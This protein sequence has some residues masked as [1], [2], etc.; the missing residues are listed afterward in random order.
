MSL[1]MSI[2]AGLVGAVAV[3]CTGEDV[4]GSGALQLS[5]TGGAVMR[6]GYPYEEPGL[7]RL[8]FVDGWRL[9]FDRYIL[10]VGEVRLH[11]Q[12]PDQQSREGP[13]VASWT[14][15][16]VLDLMRPPSGVEFATLEDLPALRHDLGLDVVVATAAAENV[17]ATPEDYQ[18]MVDNGWTFWASGTA[19]RMDAG[20]S[21]SVRFSVGFAAPTRFF[22]CVN[23]VDATRGIAI[24][25]SSTVGAYI[26]PHSTHLFWDVLA[27]G[28]AQLRFDPW[29]AVAGDDGV[30]TAE[31]LASQDLLDLRDRDGS[32]L[33]DPVTFQ[34]V[35][36]DTASVFL[37]ETDL[38]SYTIYGFRQSVHFNGL[39]FCP[40]EP[41]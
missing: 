17:S 9:T 36:Y 23:G 33:L 1:R 24:E 40:W 35:R 26:Y 16:V 27:A 3:A 34:Q 8:A 10:A 15:P 20:T 41:L 25:A 6:E 7:S 12:L 18:T 29:A 28:D 19:T 37:R 32:P 22:R 13:L 2:F 14:G 30:V 11:E 38:L 5:A 21:T 4:A 31:E 39:G